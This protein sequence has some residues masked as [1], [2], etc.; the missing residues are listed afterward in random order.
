MKPRCGLCAYRRHWVAP[1]RGRGLKRNY[2]QAETV[3]TQRR[4]FTGAW[5][6]TCLPMLM[7]RGVRVAPSRGRGLK[8]AYRCLCNG[9]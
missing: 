8:P 5:I 4:P 1:S 7:Q 9:G 2:F 3:A 6:E